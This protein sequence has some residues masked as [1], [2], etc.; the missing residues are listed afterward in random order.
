MKLNS[1]LVVGILILALAVVA[2]P[3]AKADSLPPGDPRIQT[4]GVMNDDPVYIITQNFT[5]SSPTGTS[6]IDPNNPNSSPCNSLQAGIIFNVEPECQFA[7]GINVGG[8][9]KV[10][11]SLEFIFPTVS[12]ASMTC[13][14]VTG[15]VVIF[16]NPCSVVDLGN[17][18]SAVFFTGGTIPFGAIFTVAMDGFDAG[19]A[20]GVM[21]Q[22][23]EPGT[24]LLLV[25]GFV[26]LL[27]GVG[28][29]RSPVRAQ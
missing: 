5:I 24:F 1:L 17:G 26:A 15:A 19:A 21:V 23:P 4:G 7:N 28:L 25:I 18:G 13:G 12:A 8:Q 22:T 9:G 27:V 11:D 14:N 20:G 2:A 3:V 6:P 10:I 16:T 29:K